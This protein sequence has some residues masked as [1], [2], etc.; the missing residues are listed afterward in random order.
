[1]I[2]KVTAAPKQLEVILSGHLYPDKINL[3]RESVLEYIDKGHRLITINLAGVEYI[4]CKGLGVLEF[5]YK[6]AL[7]KDG[8]LEIKGLQGSVKELFSLTHLDKRM[9]IK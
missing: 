9:E 7:E 2:L 1:M 6:K 5:L 8:R 4:D 3:L